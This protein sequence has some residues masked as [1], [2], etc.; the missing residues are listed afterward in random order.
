MACIFAG[1]LVEDAK[2]SRIRKEVAFNYLRPE[3]TSEKAQATKG[4]LGLFFLV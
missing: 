4:L 1:E 3:Y 2:C